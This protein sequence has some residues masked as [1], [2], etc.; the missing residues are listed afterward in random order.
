MEQYLVKLGII[1]LHVGVFYAYTKLS[2]RIM[3]YKYNTDD[4]S[5]P[6]I[7]NILIHSNFNVWVKYAKYAD[8]MQDEFKMQVWMAA[9]LGDIQYLQ[10]L[11][12]SQCNLFERICILIY[13]Q[14]NWN[15]SNA[16]WFMF[17]ANAN[18][19]NKCIRIVY[20]GTANFPKDAFIIE[21]VLL[22][23]TNV[24]D[25][26]RCL[27]SYGIKFNRTHFYLAV[28]SGNMDCFKYMHD[29]GGC[30]INDKVY[31][32]AIKF[33]RMQFLTYMLSTYVSWP[34]PYKLDECI[35]FHLSD[36]HLSDFHL[37]ESFS[38]HP[39][40]EHV[41]ACIKFVHAN[42]CPISDHSLSLI[43]KYDMYQTKMQTY[44][45]MEELM[46]VSLHP[47]RINQFIC[48]D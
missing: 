12:L 18:S 20:L 3:P 17:D 16:R 23:G 38:P 9:V 39:N 10:Q 37:S 5:N 44:L 30:Y 42:G 21:C 7:S 40:T 11:Y 14:H 29:N 33:G 1:T 35:Q 31:D 36:F 41:I 45:F 46:A 34:Q 13:G 43:S 25:C 28:A 48:D 32:W 4:D 26:I 15:T 24:Y 27:H 6:I 47:K 2:P 8:K 19:D 22:Y